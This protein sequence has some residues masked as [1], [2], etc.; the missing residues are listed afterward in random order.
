MKENENVVR[1]DMATYLAG[2]V[3]RIRTD[4]L[5]LRGIAGREHEPDDLNHRELTDL[6]DSLEWTAGMMELSR[7]QLCKKC[8][9]IDVVKKV[10]F[11]L[12]D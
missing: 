1:T 11:S 3:A 12:R 9:M 6:A 8:G 7:K 10:T 4:S 5:A 2:L